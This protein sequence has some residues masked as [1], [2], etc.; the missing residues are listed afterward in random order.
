MAKRGFGRGDTNQ[1]CLQHGRLTHTVTISYE[2]RLLYVA[3]PLYDRGECE[4]ASLEYIV[5]LKTNHCSFDPSIIKMILCKYF[6]IQHE[7]DPCKDNE[8][9]KSWPKHVYS[10][11]IDS[12]T[13]PRR[14]HITSCSSDLLVRVPPETTTIMTKKQCNVSECRGTRLPRKSSRC[15]LKYAK[16]M[17][18]GTEFGTRRSKPQNPLTR[19]EVREG[20]F[21]TKRS[22]VVA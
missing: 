14:R 19:N 9:L 20:S 13:Y 5:G 21:S 8:G 7:L 15:P 18:R 17:G 4:R 12:Y 10:P 16:D 2:L 6:L 1:R 22:F 3:A 11:S